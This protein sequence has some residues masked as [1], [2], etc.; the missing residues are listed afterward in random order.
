MKKFVSGLIVGVLLFAGASAFADS[1]SLIGQKVQGLFSVEKNGAKVADAVIID[2]SAYAPVRSVAEAA[3]VTLQVEGKKI[4]M[5]NNANVIDPLVELNAK[6]ETLVEQIATHEKQIKG[7][8]DNILPTYESLAEEL[9]GNG[10]LGQRAAEDYAAFKKQ[11]DTWESELAT[12]KQ[13]LTELNA[14]IAELQ[15]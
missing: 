10:S 5:T 4:I 11:V 14:Q 9:A 12:L 13:Q 6:R 15:K 7:Y 8:K 2:G 1:S 3:G